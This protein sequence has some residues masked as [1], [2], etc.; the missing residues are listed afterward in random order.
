MN[1]LNINIKHYLMDRLLEVKKLNAFNIVIYLIIHSLLSINI[2]S[3][4]G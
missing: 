4:A 2:Y 3:Q 1:L